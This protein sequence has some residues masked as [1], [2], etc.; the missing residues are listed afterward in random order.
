MN[1][2][3][4]KSANPHKDDPPAAYC[5]PCATSSFVQVYLLVEPLTAPY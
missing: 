1:M 4:G 2:H 3:F 5:H